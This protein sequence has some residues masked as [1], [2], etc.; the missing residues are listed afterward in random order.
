MS[1]RNHYGKHIIIVIIIIIINT[2]TIIITIII[3]V[4]RTHLLMNIKTKSRLHILF[5][6]QQNIVQSAPQSIG[7][8]QSVLL[9]AYE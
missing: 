8:F 2:I 1:P 3:P 4:V 6:E 7:S 5:S 9:A